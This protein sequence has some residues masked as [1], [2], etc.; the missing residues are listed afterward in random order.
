MPQTKNSQRRTKREYKRWLDY[1]IFWLLALTT[2][3]TGVAAYYTRQQFLVA[4]ETKLRQLRAY[5]TLKEFV[6]KPITDESG[7]VVKWRLVTKWQNTGDTPTRNLTTWTAKGIFESGIPADFDC[8]K[9]E[10]VPVGHTSVMGPDTELGASPI[11][12]PVE[13]L[14]GLKNKVG[15]ILIWGRI[16]YWDVFEDTPSRHT[17][18]CAELVI[19]GDF[20]QPQGTPLGF[21]SYPKCNSND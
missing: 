19:E 5:V 6:Q 4:D 9:P 1:G 11:F 3:F 8:A 15:K 13:A 2:V 14:D 12:I 16:D 20:T 10:N 18:F 21:L 7:K 17:A